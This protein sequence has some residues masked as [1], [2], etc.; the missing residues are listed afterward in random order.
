M[1][2]TWNEEEGLSGTREVK[3]MLAM[4]SRGVRPVPSSSSSEL[5]SRMTLRRLQ[6]RPEEV[7]VT[8]GEGVAGLEPKD[9]RRAMAEGAWQRRWNRTELLS[10]SCYSKLAKFKP[11][12]HHFDTS[13]EKVADTDRV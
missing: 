10:G 8:F 7:V 5:S 6:A 12:S 4:F 1:S 11:C 9:S 13:Q 3:R 2:R